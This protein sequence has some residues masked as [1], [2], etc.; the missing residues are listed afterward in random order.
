MQRSYLRS[1]FNNIYLDT[2]I[3]HQ[4]NFERLK[5]FPYSFRPILLNLTRHSRDSRFKI[6]FIIINSTK[7]WKVFLIHIAYSSFEVEECFK[8][9]CHL[10]GAQR[11]VTQATCSE[12]LLILSCNVGNIWKWFGKLECL[13]NILIGPNRWKGMTLNWNALSFYSI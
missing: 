1:V 9:L 10:T 6:T 11:K 5:C 13:Y 2:S 7:L 4:W 12:A 8:K 3:F